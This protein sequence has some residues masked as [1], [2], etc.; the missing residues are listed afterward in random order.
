MSCRRL[1]LESHSLISTRAPPL[2]GPR[3]VTQC[4]Q[5]KIKITALAYRVVGGI[6]IMSLRELPVVT[7]SASPS[8]VLSEST[9]ISLLT[10]VSSETALPTPV[11]NSQHSSNYNNSTFQLSLTQLITFSFLK[12]SFRLALVTWHRPVPLSHWPLPPGF[13]AGFSVSLQPFGAVSS[14]ACSVLPPLLY[15]LIPPEDII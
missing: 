7:V 3:Q 11:A 15:L 8:P 10:S 6:I 2:C 9:L 13:S 12:S 5:I 14:R 4:P 1:P